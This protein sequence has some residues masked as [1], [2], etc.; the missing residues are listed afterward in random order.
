MRVRVPL[1]R[2]PRCRN[3]ADVIT[4]H[5]SL[6]RASNAAG[7]AA[8]LLACALFV[9]GDSCVKLLGQQLPLGEI[10]LLRGVFSLP[11]VLLMAARR[12]LLAQLPAA[13]AN[14]R[15]Q[16]RTALEIGS[17][18]LFLAG[19]IRMTYADA[20]AIQQFVPLAVI[21]GAALLF[22]EPVG[23]RRWLATFVGLVGVMIVVRPGSGALNWPA[24]MILANVVCVA[25]RDLVTRRL[26]ASVP[27]LVVSIL[28]I[29]AVS[30]SGLLLAPFET[31]RI[32]T[33]W[34]LFLIAI[35]GICSTG[36]FYWVT[37]ALRR[38]EAAA[39]MPF[40]YALI[41]YGVLTGL[42]IFGEWPDQTTFL[43]SAIVLGAGLYA[44]HRER[45]SSAH[46]RR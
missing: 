27:T 41:P 11:I 5:A 6:D 14:P 18:I 45:A 46:G 19:L 22:G 38:G 37:E 44:L 31:W 9:A 17:T 23:W 1:V 35:A 8:M 16:L 34:E 2:G 40:R 43:G 21:A 36:G 26:G 42:F 24:L 10:L 13:A 33:G 12:G 4:T 39:V 20:I 29:G 3:G 15:L 28:S 7:V 32:P 25:G 30:L